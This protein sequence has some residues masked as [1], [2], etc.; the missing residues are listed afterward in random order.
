MFFLFKLRFWLKKC[1]LYKECIYNQTFHYFCFV[2]QLARTETFNTGEFTVFVPLSET[3]NMSTVSSPSTFLST[4]SNSIYLAIHLNQFCQYVMSVCVCVSVSD[5][6]FKNG[7]HL[8]VSETWSIITLFP[9]RFWPL[10][11]WNR[12]IALLLYRDTCCSSAT[13]R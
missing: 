10:M 3:N 1:D 8:D 4:V 9:V 11:I 7:S 6:R 5:S 2:C 12:R 13:S